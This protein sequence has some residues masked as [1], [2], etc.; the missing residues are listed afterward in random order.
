MRKADDLLSMVAT[1][2]I[3]VENAVF[4][5]LIDAIISAGIL[6]GIDI[7]TTEGGA[8]GIQIGAGILVTGIGMTSDP[9]LAYTFRRA[10]RS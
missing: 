9:G 2:T 4:I 5:V 8:T 1:L 6:I 3:T 7:R 10:I